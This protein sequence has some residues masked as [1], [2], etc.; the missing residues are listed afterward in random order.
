ML[1]S[2]IWVDFS[3][4][5]TQEDAYLESKKNHSLKYYPS[6]QLKLKE[7]FG[8]LKIRQGMTYAFAKKLN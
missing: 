6:L 8:H 5:F 4:I 1:R 3:K 2:Y 7:K